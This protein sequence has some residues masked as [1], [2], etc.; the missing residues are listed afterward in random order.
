M[1][2]ID[3]VGNCQLISRKLKGN[4]AKMSFINIYGDFLGK[5]VVIVKK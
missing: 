2:K 1:R 4:E 5:D 3:N